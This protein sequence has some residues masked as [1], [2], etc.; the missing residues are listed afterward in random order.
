MAPSLKKEVTAFVAEEIRVPSTNLRTRSFPFKDVMGNTISK[1]RWPP[2]LSQSRRK[3]E[4]GLA[5]FL[6]GRR[7]FNFLFNARR[8]VQGRSWSPTMSGA[9]QISFFWTLPRGIQVRLLETG[10]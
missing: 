7:T 8:L 2:G 9:S 10:D 6:H 3:T 1:R 5:I 4:S